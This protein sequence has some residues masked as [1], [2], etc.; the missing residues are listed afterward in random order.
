LRGSKEKKCV[1]M[2]E[3]TEKKE[4]NNE[5]IVCRGGNIINN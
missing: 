2:W 4:K 1:E 5:G 3:E